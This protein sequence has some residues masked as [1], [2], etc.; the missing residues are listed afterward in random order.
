[1]LP[2]PTETGRKEVETK[3][4]Q[5]EERQILRQDTGL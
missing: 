5:V 3:F 2:L 4:D 1:M